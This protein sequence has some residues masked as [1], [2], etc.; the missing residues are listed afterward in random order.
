[1][2]QTVADRKGDDMRSKDTALIEQIKKSIEKA[3]EESGRTPS[4]REIATE[5]GCSYSTVSRYLTEMMSRGVITREGGM[6]ETETI[7]K[8]NLQTVPVAV[9]GS[10]SCGPLTFAEENIEEYIKLP[11]SLLGA[12]K[13]FILHASGQSMIG[14]GIEDGDLVVIRQQE[15][16]EPGQ[17]V[18]ALVEDEVTLKRFFPDPQNGCIRLH[19][20]NKRMKD[21]IVDNCQIQG[22][23]VKVLKDLL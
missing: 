18:V 13:F 2:Q 10:V 11:K 15:T 8:M 23:A 3:Y 9:V 5:V 16:A 12:G 22:V 14:A 20:E 4:V 19:P 21:I 17:I 1:M 7:A 6:Y